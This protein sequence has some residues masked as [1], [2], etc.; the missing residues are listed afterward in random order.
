MWLN[1]AASFAVTATTVPS[2]G[3]AS[4]MALGP[5]TIRRAGQCSQ[6]RPSVHIADV[7]LFPLEGIHIFGGLI[8]AES[9]VLADDLVQRLVHV[10]A[11]RV[12]SPQT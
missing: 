9:A 2:A 6:R 4:A 11:M 10:L 8:V 3:S 7:P 12:A 5:A 1:K